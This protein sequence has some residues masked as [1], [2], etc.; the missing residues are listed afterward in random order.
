VK[1]LLEGVAGAGALALA[2]QEA[3]RRLQALG[4]PLPL[5]LDDLPRSYIQQRPGTD[6]YIEQEPKWRRH[7]CLLVALAYGDMAGRPGGG[8]GEVEV[9]QLQQQQQQQQQQKQPKQHKEQQ[10]HKQHKE[11]KEQQQQHKQQHKQPEEAE[12]YEGEEGGGYHKGWMPWF[13]GRS[14]PAPDDNDFIPC[15]E[16]GDVSNRPP[17][18]IMSPPS[19]IKKTWAYAIS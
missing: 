5:D 12:V 4:G 2:S 6:A 9:Q 11:H 10:Q 7:V 19:R 18:W 1:E 3:S 14:Q 16:W 15:I 17:P 8:A 13:S